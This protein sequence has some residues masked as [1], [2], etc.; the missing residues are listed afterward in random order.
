MWK[1]F[2]GSRNPF[3]VADEETD[4]KIVVQNTILHLHKWVSKLLIYRRTSSI[5]FDEPFKCHVSFP[6]HLS[7]FKRRRVGA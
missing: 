1:T 2:F 5:Y 4:V 3:S 7:N 6:K